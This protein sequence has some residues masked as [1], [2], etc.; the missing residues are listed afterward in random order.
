MKQINN[1]KFQ[2]VVN[3]TVLGSSMLLQLGCESLSWEK[4]KP[5]A[6][7]NDTVSTIGEQT[8]IPV[9]IDSAFNAEYDAL[10]DSSLTLDA[11]QRPSLPTFPPVIEET[12]I[13]EPL[14]F[15]EVDTGPVFPQMNDD[16]TYIIQRGDTLWGV[17]QKFKVSLNKL[18]NGNGLTKASVISI[19]QELKIPGVTESQS[20][21]QALTFDMPAKVYGNGDGY[22]V[23]KGDNLTKIAYLYG[24]SVSD[25]KSANGLVSDHLLVGQNLVVPS[26]GQVRD[27]YKPAVTLNSDSS[28]RT[29]GD[30]HVVRHGEFPS[31]IARIY[32]LKTNELMTMNNIS[33]PSKLQIGTRLI[34]RSGGSLPPS[35]GTHLE[36]LPIKGPSPIQNSSG[37]GLDELGPIPLSEGISSEEIPLIEDDSPI[38]PVEEVK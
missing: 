25:L 17:S 7:V 3:T 12:S 5:D 6:T 37:L 16:L 35:I 10:H 20:P 8:A 1:Q 34:V 23:Q 4:S 28:L 32:G 31:K 13:S 2:R 27:S 22:I 38:V 30:Y 21:V 26:G 36:N 15:I 33:D 18:L 11:Y 29:G 14:E 9:V 19:G 24:T